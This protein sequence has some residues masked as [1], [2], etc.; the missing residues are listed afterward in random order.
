MTR[1]KINILYENTRGGK[2]KEKETKQNPKN[3]KGDLLYEIYFS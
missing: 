3:H 1:K 2:K